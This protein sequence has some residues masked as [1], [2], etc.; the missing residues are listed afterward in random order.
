MAGV[1][2]E[3]DP[4]LRLGA[5]PAND[6]SEILERSPDRGTGPGGELQQQDRSHLHLGQ[7]ALHS[8]GVSCDAAR[9]VPV[10]GVARMGYDEVEP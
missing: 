9:R 4:R 10:G 7:G 3:P 8:L 6:G 2:A 5:E 1:E